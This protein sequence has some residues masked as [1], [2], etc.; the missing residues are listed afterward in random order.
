MWA[1]R[2]PAAPRA[3]HTCDSLTSPSSSPRPAPRVP[4]TCSARSAPRAAATESLWTVSATSGARL[5][6]RWTRSLPRRAPAGAGPRLPLRPP[7]SFRVFSARLFLLQAPP[8][9]TCQRSSGF[10]PPRARGRDSSEEGALCIQQVALN[11]RPARPLLEGTRVAAARLHEQSGSCTDNL[12]TSSSTTTEEGRP[13]A[14][15]LGVE[16]ERRMSL[17]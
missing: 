6:A 8:P 12:M 10:V 13:K 15:W 5:R 3:R 14:A 9:P 1:L 7:A 17:T 2:T 11:S 16:R 4:G